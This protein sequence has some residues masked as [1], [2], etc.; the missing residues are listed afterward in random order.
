MVANNGLTGTCY[1]CGE[2]GHLSSD[3]IDRGR[4][5]GRHYMRRYG[6]H[7]VEHHADSRQRDHH[8]KYR[9]GHGGA[10]PGGVRQGDAGHEGDFHGRGRQGGDQYRVRFSNDGNDDRC[11]ARTAPA[12]EYQHREQFKHTNS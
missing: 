2:V 7:G 3:H 4:H 11:H 8:V 12:I 6:G 5:Q 9:Q 10:R 1:T